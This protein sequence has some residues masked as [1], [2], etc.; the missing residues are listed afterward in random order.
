MQHSARP[1]DKP[2]Q[3][4]GPNALT[5]LAVLATVVIVAYLGYDLLRPRCD[6][7]F[8][9]T[10]VQIKGKIDDLQVKGVHLAGGLEVGRAQVQSL[11]DSAQQMA[12]NLKTC[13]IMQQVGSLGADRLQRCIDGARSYGERILQIAGAIGDARAAQS[14]GDAMLASQKLGQADE[15]MQSVRVAEKALAAAADPNRQDPPPAPISPGAHDT[16]LDPY[17]ITVGSTVAGEVGEGGKS[18]FYQFEYNDPKLRRDIIKISLQ[19][20]STTLQPSMALYNADKSSAGQG[21]SGNIAGSDFSFSIVADSGTTYNLEVGS[22]YHQTTGKYQ[23]TIQPEHAYDQYEP[24]DDPTTATPIQ[25]GQVIDANIM[26]GSDDDWYRL[27]GVRNKTV[28][29]HIENRS[30][31]LQPVIVIRTVDKSPLRNATANDAG[32]DVSLTFDA[33]VG[34]DYFMIISSAYHRSS[35]AYRLTTQ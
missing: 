16:I 12:V 8:E 4:K 26:D 15:A 34:Q 13:C 21:G 22:V 18:T 17:P 27:G 20:L 1:R 7:I 3:W 11:S 23:L 32:A 10:A 33:E 5:T 30:R 29:V 35:G 31:S 25:I 19:N 24:N 2:R 6:G 14:H 9:Q 28:T